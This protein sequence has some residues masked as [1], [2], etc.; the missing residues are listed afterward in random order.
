MTLMNSGCGITLKQGT[1]IEDIFM[2]KYF[3]K[4]NY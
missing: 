1:F 4:K 2:S 3:H